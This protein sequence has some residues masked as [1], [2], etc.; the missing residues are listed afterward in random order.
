V[1]VE[2]SQTSGSR[3]QAR[4][5]LEHGRPVFLLDEL[6]DQQWAKDHA[7]RPGTHVV[8]SPEEISQAVERLT[9]SDALVA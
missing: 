1:V 2:A 8:S 5:A 9:S 6:L 7:Q 3:M 4:L